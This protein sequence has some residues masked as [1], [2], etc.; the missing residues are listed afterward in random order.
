[1]N[2]E[3][4][5]NRYARNYGQIK[6]LIVKTANPAARMATIV[7]ILHHKMPN[8]YWTG[9][10]CLADGELLVNVYQGPV[11]CLKLKKDTG[12]CWA[13]INEN[14][15]VVVPDVH[16][17]E[18]HIA[19][20]SQTNSEIVVPLR[21]KTGEVLGVLDIDSKEFNT[22]DEIDADELQKIVDLVYEN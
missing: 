14:K 19:C 10:Y 5:T 4:K 13:G 15:A 12:V 17:F 2:P 1:M 8:F 9:F 3:S 18:G 16:Q 11:A 20:S 22:F 6:E 7:A 21:N